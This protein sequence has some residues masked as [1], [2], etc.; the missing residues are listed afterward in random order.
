MAFC[1]YA[2]A[3]T[4]IAVAVWKR[5]SISDVAVAGIVGVAEGVRVIVGICV[6]GAGGSPEHPAAHIAVRTTIIPSPNSTGRIAAFR[7]CMAHI[8][9][10]DLFTPSRA[11]STGRDA[12][13]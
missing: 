13:W 6:V 12:K 10:C 3:Q 4:T 1:A 8:P 9:F 7:D 11:P 5:I 2:V